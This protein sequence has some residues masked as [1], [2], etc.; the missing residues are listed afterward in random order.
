[1]TG[2]TCLV[3]CH[4]YHVVLGSIVSNSHPEENVCVWC[5]LIP[6]LVSLPCLLGR[7]YS[8]T[9]LTRWKYIRKTR[10]DD[11]EWHESKTN[12]MTRRLTWDSF[13]FLK[14]VLPFSLHILYTVTDKTFS[15]KSCS[16]FSQTVC[17]S[18]GQF[19]SCSLPLLKAIRPQLQ[20]IQ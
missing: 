13:F 8:S 16:L 1:M 12:D 17:L 3:S 19:I 9:R 4:D 7:K 2:V 20:V 6:G 18:S 15:H 10:S 11:N 5:S 14:N